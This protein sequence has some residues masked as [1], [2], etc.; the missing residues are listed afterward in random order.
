MFLDH[1]DVRTDGFSRHS[2]TWGMTSVQ[3]IKYVDVNQIRAAIEESR[4]RRGRKV[5]KLYLYFDLKNGS[6][7]KVQ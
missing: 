2:G 1:V 3:D 7:V 6:S 4:G 5:E